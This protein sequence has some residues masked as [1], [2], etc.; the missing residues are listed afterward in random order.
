[1]Y[2]QVLCLGAIVGH[3]VELLLKFS[4]DKII[5][6]SNKDLDNDK[7]QLNLFK[8]E[9]KMINKLKSINL[10]KISPIESLNL[11]NDLKE[12]FSDD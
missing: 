3:S 5:S 1:M 2:P 8:I 11:L 9:S 4:K 6:N 7:S 10:N 12:E